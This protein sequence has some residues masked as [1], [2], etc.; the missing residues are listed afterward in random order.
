MT[1]SPALTSVGTRWPSSNRPGPAA[2]DLALLGALLG[3]VGDDN[4][5][6]GGLLPLARLNHDAILQRPQAELL[7]PCVL[8]PRTL[9]GSGS[10]PLA[11]TCSRWVRCLGP[12]MSGLG[13]GRPALW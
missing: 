8:P 2:I 6:G 12:S 11:G 1:L 13:A 4:A 7:A 5:G 3:R 10:S 9:S